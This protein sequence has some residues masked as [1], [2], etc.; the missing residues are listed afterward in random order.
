M[1]KTYIQPEM[2]AVVL[3]QQNNLLQNASPAGPVSN[4]DSNNGIG[5]GDGTVSGGGDVKEDKN[6]WDEEW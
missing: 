3:L 1:K 2:L 5:L 4:V 6:I